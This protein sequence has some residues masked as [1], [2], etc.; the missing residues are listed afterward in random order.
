[1]N[2]CHLSFFCGHALAH[3][4]DPCHYPRLQMFVAP[5]EKEVEWTDSGLEGSFRWLHRVWHIAQQWRA[6]ALQT[7]AGSINHRAL[8]DVERALRRK[9]HE[10]IRRVSSDVDV[11]KQFNTA[12]SAMMELVNDL[13]AFT[14]RQE[15]EPTSGAAVVA[16]EAIESLILM[17]SPFA[18]HT[19]EE[20]WEQFG[21]SGTLSAAAWPAVDAEAAK[22]EEIE[23][24]VQVNGKVRGR[25][26]VAPDISDT[27][28]EK[29][30]LANPAVQPYTQG[31]TIKKVVIAK[32]RLVSIVV[33]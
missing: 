22:A 30:A 23:I 3:C 27:E 32:G 2:D 14:K 16:K 31:K 8:A 9:T 4:P 21:H 12:I 24:P 29:V 1:M 17:L 28:L 25:V 5:P 19:A 33:A 26:T 7:S 10:M 11:R 20:L 18:P 15:T 13:Y 6:R